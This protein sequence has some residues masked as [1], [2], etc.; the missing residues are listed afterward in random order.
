MKILFTLFILFSS[1]LVFAEDI[2]SFEIEGMS[3]GESL[4]DYF[5][6]EEILNNKELIPYKNDDFYSIGFYN[7]SKFKIYD[8]VQ[9]SLKKN[10][11]KYIIY[12]I[13]GGIFFNENIDDCL[14]KKNQIVNEVSKLFKNANKVDD[15]TFNHQF[16]QTGK[17]KQTSVYFELGETVKGGTDT[18]MI[19]CTDWSSEI[20][21]EYNW[22]DNLRVSIDSKEYDY[23]IN[24]EAYK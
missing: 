7:N 15:G 17:S 11:A 1:S 18:I 5:N 2:S 22:A 9:I 14:I 4:L 13:A 16:D 6:K 20:E 3:V 12:S 8:A 10:D 24:N 21:N 23:W 19:Y